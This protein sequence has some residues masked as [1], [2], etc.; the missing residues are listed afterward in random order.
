MRKTTQCYISRIKGGAGIEELLMLYRNKKPDDP[1]EGKWLGIGG[2][3][4]PGET[5]GEANIR[6]VYEETGIRLEPD[7]CHFHGI[8]QFFNTVCED[9]EIYLYSA[10]VPE[11]TEFIEC[12]EGELHWI[13]RDKIL[14]LN[15]WEGDK[16]FLEPLIAGKDRIDLALYY[17]GDNLVRVSRGCPTT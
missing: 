3:V 10:N 2:K 7:A 16:V 12:D 17:E 8:I 1:N 11:N 6:E 15:M 13:A 14:D 4:E 5:P 9:E